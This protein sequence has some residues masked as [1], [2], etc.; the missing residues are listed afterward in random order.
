MKLYHVTTSKKAKKYAETGF[1]VGP[2]RGFTT[3]MAA[4]AWAIKVG[5][6]VIY[7]IDGNPAKMHKL[8]D[9]HNEFGEAWWC[10]FDVKNYKCVF[11]GDT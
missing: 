5:R 4:M 9:H 3:L 6:K 11:S 8:P 1:I 10:D 7:E 2:V